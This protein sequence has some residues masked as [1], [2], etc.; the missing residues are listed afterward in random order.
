[1]PSGVE[2]KSAD[3]QSPGL[4]PSLP[5]RTDSE[6]DFVENVENSIYQF[7]PD[8]QEAEEDDGTDDDYEYVD[9][10]FRPGGAVG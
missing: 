10:L 5:I 9:G 1:M 4:H 7:D 8:E 3:G 2:R 6:E